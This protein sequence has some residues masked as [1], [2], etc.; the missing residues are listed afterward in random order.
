M[1]KTLYFEGAGCVP[2]GEVENC[3]IR[4][5]FHNDKGEAIYLEITGVEVTNRMSSQLKKYTYAGVI[6]SCH[7]ILG[8]DDENKHSIHN[9]NEK[10]FEYTKAEILHIVNSLGCSFDQVVILPF[11]AGYR[12]FKD[13]EGYNFGDEFQFNAERTV[14]A[15]EIE[16]HF[17][18]LEKSEGKQYPNFSLWVDQTNPEMFHLLRHFNGYNRHWSIQNTENWQETIEETTLGKYAC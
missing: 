2:C 8:D 14:R 1:K 16:S 4:T 9:R 5:A 10:T 3:R 13:H 18:N 12:V 7:Y 11:L 6:D 17:Y 15:E